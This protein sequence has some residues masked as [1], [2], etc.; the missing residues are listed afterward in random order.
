MWLEVDC[1]LQIK[2]SLISTN[3]IHLFLIS[4]DP[5][6][7]FFISTNPIKPFPDWTSYLI[8]DTAEIARW[9]RHVIPPDVVYLNL[10]SGKFLRFHG[11]AVCSRESNTIHFTKSLVEFVWDFHSYF[12]HL[13]PTNHD[14][15][16]LLWFD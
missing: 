5:I 3:T 6:K 11:Y 12:W 16:T 7:L 13:T 1:I 9:C 4:T 8:F 2:R 10:C 15:K 14:C